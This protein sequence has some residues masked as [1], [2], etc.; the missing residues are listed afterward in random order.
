MFSI[1]WEPNKSCIW[2]IFGSQVATFDIWLLTLFRPRPTLALE[3]ALG[4]LAFGVSTD[5]RKG[6]QALW[7][8]SVWPVLNEQL[9]KTEGSWRLALTS[10]LFFYNLDVHC[11]CTLL[12]AP[13]PSARLPTGDRESPV[14]EPTR[15]RRSANPLP[16][17]LAGMCTKPSTTN[18]SPL[19]AT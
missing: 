16:H 14:P 5:F 19:P 1:L 10:P 17:F 15:T 9:T 18:T 6:L 2:V 13:Q 8:R 11:K 4:G 3:S 12:T 7:V